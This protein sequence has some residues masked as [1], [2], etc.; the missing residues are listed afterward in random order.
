MTLWFELCCCE[1]FSGPMLTT[2]QVLRDPVFPGWTH[3]GPV[4]TLTLG[5][6]LL[7]SKTPIAV[8]QLHPHPYVWSGTL[9]QAELLGQNILWENQNLR[10][11]RTAPSCWGVHCCA[12]L[13]LWA[14][15][16][17]QWDFHLRTGG[18]KGL[19]GQRCYIIS[20][21]A[22][23]KISSPQIFGEWWV[24]ENLQSGCQEKY[25]WKCKDFKGCQGKCALR[26]SVCLAYPETGK[27]GQQFHPSP[28]HLVPGVLRKVCSPPGTRSFIQQMHSLSCTMYWV[29]LWVR[30][31]SRLLRSPEN[32]N[33][34]S[35]PCGVREREELR[36]TPGNRTVDSRSPGQIQAGGRFTGNVGTA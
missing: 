2:P 9:G 29:L 26:R 30:H 21:T 15:C 8:T 11:D 18:R 5:S 35:L 6:H 28:C 23:Y 12:C 1:E 24:T 36:T 10:R 7:L 16:Q 31:T 3:Q 32:N 20:L 14:G 17:P 25:L 4:T 19:G 33:W 13:E 22:L 34:R 27:R